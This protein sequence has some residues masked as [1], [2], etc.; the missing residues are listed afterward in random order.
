M[1]EKVMLKKRTGT[2]RNARTY[3]LDGHSIEAVSERTAGL[4]RAMK[5]EEKNI[6]IIRLSLE[7]YLLRWQDRFGE[8]ANLRFFSGS[9]MGRPYLAFELAGEPFDPTEGADDESDNWSKRIVAELGIS[10]I[11]SYVHG[12]NQLR[13]D[14][15]R[16]KINPVFRIL[17]AM[18]LAVACGLAAGLLP[19]EARRFLSENILEQL[20][21]TFFGLLGMV[22]GPVIFFSIL[23]GV[24]GIGDV[25]TLGRV[26][27]GV[28]LS[29]CGLTFG[30]ALVCGALFPFLFSVRIVGQN[31]AGTQFN[32]IFAMLL[33]IVPDNILGPFV[34][35]NT[36]QIILL[37]IAFGIILLIVGKKAERLTQLAGEANAVLQIMMGW[38]SSLL[39]VMIFIVMFK[40]VLSGSGAL[41]LTIW[42][43]LLIGVLTILAFGGGYLLLSSARL[44]VSPRL[45]LSKV[46]PVFLLGVT[47][48]SST[49]AFGEVSA[50]CG[51]KM[52]VSRSLNSFAVP[53][54]MILCMGGCAIDLMVCSLYCASIY[55]VELSLV[56]IAVAV[57]TSGMLA[58][59]S[60]PVPGALLA[61]YSILFTQLGLPSEG[62]V[63]A[64]TLNV[65]FDFFATGMNVTMVPLALTVQ[66]QKLGMVDRAVLTEKNP[67]AT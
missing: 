15:F 64:M 12:K 13:L 58:I 25:A 30:A 60:P 2:A 31:D 24:C 62:L 53:L 55:R 9:R 18:T 48:A 35:G 28:I 11:Y 40:S 47:T 36:L 32:E 33:D 7:E 59:A 6:T 22:A 45:L 41:F 61:C 37:G 52:G 5:Y 66:A 63:M 54:G 65:F 1:K 56:S 21:D 49:A 57:L 14:L 42:K 29:F 26:G 39:P 43:P 23:L 3:R 44:H 4:L 16:K 50:C 67:E 34:A 17:I 10:P 19:E 46:M 51:K 38:V 20:G 8:K 27:K